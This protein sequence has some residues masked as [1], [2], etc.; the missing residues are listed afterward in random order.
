MD[1]IL[2]K[3]R[4]LLKAEM[5][6][7]RLQLRHT[8]QQAA[9]YIAAVLLAVLATGMLN[10]ALYLYLAPHLDN[11]GAALAVAIVD[12]VLAVVAVIVAGRLQ[13]GPEVDAVK[14][15]REAA[16]A[17][18]AADA[19]RV[20]IQVTDLQDDIK[21]IRT[22]VTDLMSFSG[23]NLASLLQWV[24]ALFRILLRRKEL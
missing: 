3:L 9:F 12:I 24:P 1:D 16:M 10:I 23:K 5:I 20:K 2:V 22:T 14:S 6:L 21:R 18:L 4:L 7:F 15:L 8:V 11:A 19:E 13:L 17:S